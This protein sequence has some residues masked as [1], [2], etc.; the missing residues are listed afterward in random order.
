MSSKEKGK[1]TAHMSDAAVC[2]VLQRKAKAS[3]PLHI[4]SGDIGCELGD[5]LWEDDIQPNYSKHRV[6]VS[7]S[8]PSM[9]YQQCMT[10]KGATLMIKFFNVKKGLILKLAGY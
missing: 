2:I 5:R 7:G 8:K 9:M 10:I 3:I 6:S 1:K 4:L